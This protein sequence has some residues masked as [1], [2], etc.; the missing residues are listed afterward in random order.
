MTAENGIPIKKPST[1]ATSSKKLADRLEKYQCAGPGVH[2]MHH[3]CAGKETK[4]TEGYTDEVA[5]VIHAAHHEE[6]PDLRATSALTAKSTETTATGELGPGESSLKH[7]LPQD[8]PEKHDHPLAV[9]VEQMLASPPGD[10]PK[11]CPPGLWR[12]LVT[13]TIHPKDPLVRCPRAIKAIDVE[14]TDLEKMGTWDSAHP[15]EAENAARIYPDAHFARVFAIVGIKHYGRSKEHHKWKGRIVLSGDKI[16][17]ATG[18]WAVFAELGKVPSTM[19]ACRAFLSVCA[20]A[21]D[22]ILLHS[23]CVRAYVQ[24]VL[25]GPPMFIRLPKARQP[26]AWSSFKDPVCRLVKAL[27][28]HPHA[29]DFWHDRF[30]AE[31]IAL[32]PKTIDGWPSMYV[33]ELNNNSRIIICVYVDDLVILGPKAMYPVLEALRKEIE[34]DDPHTLKKYLG[35]FHHFLETTVNGEKPVTIQFDMADYFRSAFEIFVTETGET[36][37]PASTPFAPEI[38]SEDLDNLLNTPD[39]LSAKA[40]SFIMKLMYGARMAMPQICV[41]VSRLA[42]QITKWSADSDRRLLRV[43]VTCARTRTK[44]SPARSPSPT[45]STSR[46]SRGLTLTSTVTSCPRKTRTASSSSSLD[47]KGGASP[48]PGAPTNR[49]RRR[50]TPRRPRPCPFRTAASKGPSPSRSS[51]KP[52]LE[53]RWNALS[54]RAT[55][56]A[57]SP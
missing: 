57:S 21:E 54:R 36:Q 40:A 15:F 26:E 34:M 8:N 31:P 45:G 3:P 2:L 29:G 49:D 50:C 22:L 42:N 27:Y 12:S 1:V 5:E 11:N 52:C 16:K 10:R 13:K 51:S 48:W 4:R 18:D 47:A 19:S 33:R 37:K 6:A 39:K 23:D 30:Q 28:G 17:T 24:A 32:E 7:P 46:S 55:R 9:E 35:C 44:C 56:L 38:N 43:Y 53:S 20:V 25:K 41:I 14:R